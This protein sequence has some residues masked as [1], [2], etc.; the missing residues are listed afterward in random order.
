MAAAENVEDIRHTPL[1]PAADLNH[2]YSRSCCS[3]LSCG[4]SLPNEESLVR[5]AKSEYSEAFHAC[6]R[7]SRYVCV[8]GRRANS[9]VKKHFR[10]RGIL[11]ERKRKS[12]REREGKKKKKEEEEE[13]KK[14]KSACLL[15]RSPFGGITCGGR[16]EGRK[17]GRERAPCGSP[18]RG[19]LREPE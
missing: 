11:P 1:V 7:Q 12:E 17:E 4:L 8:K 13:K 9:S 16:K 10:Q 15:R 3:C 18:L 5:S 6:V 19:A 14:K 2:V